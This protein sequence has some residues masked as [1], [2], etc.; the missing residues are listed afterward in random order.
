MEGLEEEIFQDAP[1]IPEEFLKMSK[2]EL[3]SRARLLDNE[4]RVLKDETQRLTLEKNGLKERVKEN[5]DK[6]LCRTS[7]GDVPTFCAYLCD[8]NV[9]KQS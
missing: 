3:R 6:V 4:I 9:M 5:K 8:D 7:H 1:G 2:E